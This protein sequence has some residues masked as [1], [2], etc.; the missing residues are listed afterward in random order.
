M[1]RAMLDILGGAVAGLAGAATLTRILKTQLYGV[2]ATDPATFLVVPVVLAA[3][4]SI[5]AY[6]PAR[7]ATRIDPMAAFRSE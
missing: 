4:A 2:T 1:A 7:R 3:V 5:A 6:I